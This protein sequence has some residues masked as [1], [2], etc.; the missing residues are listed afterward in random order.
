MTTPF[1][2]VAMTPS[3]EASL[4]RRLM[5]LRRPVQKTSNDA[6]ILTAELLRLFILEARNRAVAEAEFEHESM[7]YSDDEISSPTERENNKIM[8]RP[9]HIRMIAAEILMDFS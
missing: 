3:F 1:L 7:S 8:I 2:V 5:L 4:T 6:V 9:E